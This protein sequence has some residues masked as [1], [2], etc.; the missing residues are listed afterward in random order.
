[1]PLPAQEP[2]NAMIDEAV[3]HA[4]GNPEA[5]IEDDKIAQQA[6]KP[7]TTRKRIV[8]IVMIGSPHSA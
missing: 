5:E 2:V 8:W 7:A 6:T 4:F 1:M 3:A